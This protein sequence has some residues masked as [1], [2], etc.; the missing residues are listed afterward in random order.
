MKA[1]V[2]IAGEVED[3]VVRNARHNAKIAWIRLP[4]SL[5]VS[6]FLFI[7]VDSRAGWTWLAALVA[8][9]AFAAYVRA[10][11]MVGDL[12]FRIPHL[13]AIGSL[14]IA[15]VALGLL[16]WNSGSEVA[17]LASLVAL[18][19][20][21]FYGVSGGYKSAPIL[22]VLVSPPLLALFVMLTSF[23]WKTLDFGPAI[24]TTF[25]TLGACATVAFTGWALHKSDRGLE[26]ANA[27]LRSLTNRLTLLADRER[28]ASTAKD[29]FLA[30]VSHEIRTPL[31]GIIGLSATLDTRT[32]SPRDQRAVDVIRQ[33]GE[34]LER[35]ISDVLDA[36]AIEAGGIHLKAGA[37]DPAML[38]RSTIALMEGDA[39]AK[40]LTLSL[41]VSPETPPWLLGDAVR[42]RQITLNLLSNAIKYTEEGGVSLEVGLESL[43]GEDSAP[44]LRLRV[45]DTGRGF[46]LE[47]HERLFERFERGAQ[48]GNDP[49]AGLGL[50]LAITR[51]LVDVMGGEIHVFSTAGTGS[52]F[53]VLLPLPR[54]L[55]PANTT[56]AD[57]ESTTAATKLAGSERSLRV[58]LVEDHPIN[59]LVVTSM[60]EAIGAEIETCGDGREAVQAAARTDFDVVLMDLQMPTMDGY[61]ATRAIRRQEAESGK[62]PTAIIMLTA[63]TGSSQVEQAIQAGCNAHLTKPVTPARLF[64]ALEKVLHP[65]AV[66]QREDGALGKQS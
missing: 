66:A 19:S 41:S 18:F 14:S 11:L 56:A 58:L 42:I 51:A 3:S 59:R 15:W 2:S 22:V 20:L 47:S 35:L 16:L 31:N 54:V 52:T 37:F 5:V 27:D 7:F 34:M 36:A 12:R 26:A 50:G 13:V 46:D 43:G 49:S 38:A 10:R 53:E 32:L 61:E 39:A 30:N 62:S 48:I 40:G 25:A 64:E 21:S 9:E 55:P 57:S 33:S 60:L 1:D 45:A 23:A 63:S 44:R 29:T 17:R 24:L 28:I 6:G 65:E 8:I 4:I